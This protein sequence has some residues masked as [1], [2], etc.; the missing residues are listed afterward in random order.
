MKI[1]QSQ[2]PTDKS[3]KRKE[4]KKKDFGEKNVPVL[5]IVYIKENKGKKEVLLFVF[6]LLLYHIKYKNL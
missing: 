1:T 5:P 6:F 4:K 3:P 2:T